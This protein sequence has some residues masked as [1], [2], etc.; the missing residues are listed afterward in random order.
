ATGWKLRA[1][2]EPSESDSFVSHLRNYM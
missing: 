1:I 2:G